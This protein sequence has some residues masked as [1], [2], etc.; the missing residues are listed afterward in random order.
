[1]SKV[2]EKTGKEN[3]CGK[4]KTIYKLDDDDKKYI[5]QKGKKGEVYIEVEN[6][7]QKKIEKGECLNPL[8]NKRLQIL[9]KIIKKSPSANV[10]LDNSSNKRRVS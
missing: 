1:M 7:V 3:V 10:V 8:I 5:K 2:Y 4:E 9:N 6:Y